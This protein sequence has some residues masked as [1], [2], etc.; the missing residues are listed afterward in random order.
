MKENGPEPLLENARS[1]L[2][3]PMTRDKRPFLFIAAIAILLLCVFHYFAPLEPASVSAYAGIMLVLA[4][5]LCMV[6]PIRLLAVRTRR[7]ATL[8]AGCGILVILAALSWPAPIMRSAGRAD[9][10][11]D[12]L[13]EYS[14]VERHEVLVHATP[15]RT[16]AA[17]REVTF[18]DIR[19]YDTLMRIRA[20]A[21]GHL[22]TAPSMGK[23]RI[24]KA[25]SS[26]GSGFLPLYEDEREIVMGMAGQPWSS[27]RRPK[28][29]TAA[30]YQAFQDAESVKVAFNLKIEDQGGGFTRVTTET[31]IGATD[32]AGRRIMARYWRLVYPGSGMIRRMWMNAVRTRAE[33]LVGRAFQLAKPTFQW[34]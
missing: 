28:I 21:G 16:A 13:P 22:R 15:E 19:V 10:L 14:F 34:A 3:D 1:L 24:L 26:P 9:H 11:D 7:T 25:I 6:K 29:R 30:D 12:Y 20:L 5:L 2:S 8:V 32:D 31:R 27:A 23:V 4:G 18:D 33:N 17:L